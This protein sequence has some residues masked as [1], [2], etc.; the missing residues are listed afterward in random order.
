[1]KRNC[2]DEPGALNPQKP[3]LKVTSSRFRGCWDPCKLGY[4]LV[5][6]MRGPMNVGPQ[7]TPCCTAAVPASTLSSVHTLNYLLLQRPTKL[8]NA[9]FRILSFFSH[10]TLLIQ[11]RIWLIQS[12]L[13]VRLSGNKIIL[14]RIY[15]YTVI[16]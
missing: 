9:P 12:S 3:T 6:G 5:S 13:P 15:L 7:R 10:S 11:F 16:H 1:M 14:Y 2:D 8:R 4:N